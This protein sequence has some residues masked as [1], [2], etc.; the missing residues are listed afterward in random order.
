MGDISAAVSVRYAS[1]AQRPKASVNFLFDVWD[2]FL[3]LRRMAPL[4]SEVADP[5][6]LAHTSLLLWRYDV[7]GLS[8][9][10]LLAFGPKKVQSTSCWS[11]LNF[12]PRSDPTIDMRVAYGVQT[13]GVESA[14]PAP[15]G[16]GVGCHGPEGGLWGLGKRKILMVDIGKV[17][18]YTPAKLVA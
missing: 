12:R 8:L 10:N 5:L 14:G 6:Q 18:A 17:R 11:S 1:K 3:L 15:A 9:L 13:R 2:A 4:Q 16:G 7:K